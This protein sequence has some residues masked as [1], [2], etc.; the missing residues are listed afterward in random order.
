MD[1]KTFDEQ[2]EALRAVNQRLHEK[3]A[4]MEERH[5]KDLQIAQLQAH[6]LWVK[7]WEQPHITE[8]IDQIESG[9]MF[10]QCIPISALS[11]IN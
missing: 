6:R 1:E 10:P 3:I 9:N 7:P 11:C 8:A 4:Q 5:A 2:I